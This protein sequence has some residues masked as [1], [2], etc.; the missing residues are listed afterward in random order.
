[1]IKIFISIIYILLFL[2]SNSLAEKIVYLD[3]DYLLMNSNKGKKILKNLD[4]INLQN[5]KKLEEKEKLL[6][7]EEVKI[8]QQKNILNID[9][10][11][12]KVK[13]FKIKIE[14]HRSEKDLL[15]SSFNKRKET[16]INNFIKMVDKILSKYVQNNS[17]DLVLN[18]KDILMGKNSYNITN[19]IMDI[20][21]NSTD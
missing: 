17:I 21:N 11:N 6:K 9:K 7:E 2:S 3:V 20:I 5:I 1:M 16:D 19:N 13:N 12:E 14:E 15:V 8:I 4:E 10:Y 18:K